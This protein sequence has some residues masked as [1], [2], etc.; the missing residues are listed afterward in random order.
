MAGA[1]VQISVDDRAVR[2]LFARL[3]A[4]ADDLTPAMDRIG[5]AVAEDVRR[6]FEEGQGP[7]RSPWPSSL[8]ARLQGGRTLVDSGRLAASITH[9][10]ASRSVRVGTN[11]LNAAIH[12]FGGTI[13]AKAG[14]RLK[15]RLADGS[16]VS[17]ISVNI[18]ARPFLGIDD[19]ER[20]IVIGEIE[21]WLAE[22]AG[23]E[24]SQ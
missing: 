11:V 7:D 14:G 1:S 24:A 13:A 20:D 12:Q 5:A 16:F 18:P 23:P 17:P 19:E 8:R 4:S 10:P 2:A 3:A 22:Q 6:R 9:E 15:F 21:A